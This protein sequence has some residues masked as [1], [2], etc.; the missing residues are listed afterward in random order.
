MLL[1]KI[2]LSLCL[3]TSQLVFPPAASAVSPSIVISQV[4]TGGAGS[5]AAKQEFIELFNNSVSDVD[6]TGWCVTY[7]SANNGSQSQVGCLGAPASVSVWLKAGSYITFASTAFEAAT[8]YKGDVLFMYNGGLAATAGHVRVIDA[9][10]EE[11]DKLAWGA[12]ASP[13]TTAATAADGGKV[14]QRKQASPA[15]LQ[16]TD[17]NSADFTIADLLMHAGGLYEIETITDVCPNMP[18]A[19][20]EIPAGYLQNSQGDCVLDVVPLHVTE[21]LPN[22]VGS[23]SGSEYIELFN[24]SQRSALLDNYTLYV[25]VN[26][27][28]SYQFPAGATIAPGAYSVFYNSAVPF[29]L[30]NTTSKVAVGANDGSFTAESAVYTETAEGEAWA[31]IGNMWQLTNRPT[32]AGDNQASVVEPEEAEQTAA[33]APCPAGKYRHPLTNRCRNIEA[34][35]ALAACDADQ[36]RNPETGR[37]RKIA[38]TSTVTPCKEGQYRSEETNR[39][40]NVVAAS[41]ELKP[42]KEGQERNPDTNRCRNVASATVPKAGYAVEAVRDGADSFIGWW[43]LGGVGILALGYAGWEWRREITNVAKRAVAVFMRK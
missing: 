24:P 32:P 9:A 12:A 4:Q 29:T 1:F 30:V 3:L 28:K 2:I 42:C 5:D 40:R 25:G 27:E 19:Q 37:C 18:D 38:T 6:V 36:Y 34:D 7:S 23:D 11:V 17:N 26:G 10:G 39:C 21:L 31:L 8:G 20:A 43:A 14:L 35:A 15:I 41:A 16:D 13:E 33:L 22:S